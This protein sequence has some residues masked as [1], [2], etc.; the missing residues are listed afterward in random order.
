MNLSK[1]TNTFILLSIFISSFFDVNGLLRKFA[2]LLIIIYPFF[3][4]FF[5]P[6]IF[7]RDKL[8]PLF[9][10]YLILCVSIVIL[11]SFL[12]S[13]AHIY[14]SGMIAA[15]MYLIYWYVFSI[16]NNGKKQLNKLNSIQ[17]KNII[18]LNFL[19]LVFKK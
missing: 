16:I 5:K 4:F 2:Y 11:H 15:N 3:Y 12:S 7:S 18:E 8:M 17:E 14:F 10:L 9:V 19:N 6:K 13:T 1:K